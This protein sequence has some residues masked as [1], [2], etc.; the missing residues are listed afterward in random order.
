MI[1]CFKVDSQKSPCTTAS[2]STGQELQEHGL[3]D[4]GHGQLGVLL[5]SGLLA[6]SDESLVCERTLL[7]NPF[8]RGPSDD[9]PM[10]WPILSFDCGVF[11]YPPTTPPIAPSAGT[12]SKS[13]S[14]RAAVDTTYESTDSVCSSNV[15]AYATITTHASSAPWTRITWC[16]HMLSR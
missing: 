3:V 13:A 5:L 1:T 14:A 4:S 9:E 2:C 7:A 6:L 11:P 10:P 12:P 8:S 15:V 16:N